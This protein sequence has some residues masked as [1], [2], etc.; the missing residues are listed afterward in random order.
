MKKFNLLYIIVIFSLLL[1]V[2]NL[3]ILN[4][5]R[6]MNGDARVVNYSGLV[7]GATQRLVKLELSYRPNDELMARLEEYLYGLAGY[8]NSY[9]IVYMDYDP[10]Q[11]SVGDLILIWDELK[12]SIYNYRE[13]LVTGDA[14]LEVSE[15]H[16]EKADEATHYAEY[17]SEGKIDGTV[18]LIRAGMI[19]ISVIVII[20]VVSLYL[21]R[22]SERRQMEILRENNQRLESAIHEANRA[23]RAKSI[24]LSNMSHDIRTPL[25]GIIG[26]TSI[27]LGNLTNTERMRD[28]LRKIENSSRL[29]QSLVNDVLDMSKIESGKFFLNSAEIFLPEFMRNLINVVGQQIKT[30]GQELKV[31][32]F[33]VI[34]ENI[35]GDQLRLNQLFLNI[36]SNSVKFTPAG[37][38]IG[39]IIT[40]LPCGR[41]GFACFEFICYDTG[42]GMS[43]EFLQIIFDSFSRE[44]DSRIDKIE[45]SGL[46]LS[47]TKRIVDIM[48]GGIQVE[49]EK[50]KGTK[51]TVRL[52]FPISGQD[53][54]L[55]KLD[56]IRVLVADGDEAVCADAENGLKSMGVSAVAKCNAA[57]VPELLSGGEKFDAVIIDWEMPGIS[58]HDLC[59]RIRRG[60][61]GKLPIIISSAREWNDIEQE[62]AD[63]GITGFIQKPLFRSSLLSKIREA[64][65]A[66]TDK[67]DISTLRAGLRLDG[68]HILMAE[69]NDLNTEIAVEILTAAGII[70]DCA[71]N[72]KEAVDIFNG[73]EIF[74]YD[75]ILMDMQMPVMTGCEASAAIRA[76]PRADASSIPI[77]AMTANAFEED[78]RE[79][80]AAG[81]NAHVSKPVNFE[82]L[83]T[84]ISKFISVASLKVPSPAKSETAAE[85]DSLLEAVIPCGVNVT[86]GLARFAGNRKAYEK[87]L[88]KYPDDK[89]FGALSRAILSEDFNAALKAAHTLK[90][91]A[92]NLSMD[93]FAETLFQL[94]NSLKKANNSQ[95]LD[96]YQQARELNEALTEVIRRFVN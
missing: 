67:P 50:N 70:L 34:H 3:L 53:A 57:D 32:A 75:A 76:L 78:I 85:P 56:G 5:V 7:R 14:L 77:I 92:L 91:I 44:K 6:E 33:S 52:E 17:G 47:I 66:K 46:G 13:G 37:G 31:S 20:V 65:S 49:S 71:I 94:E 51:F 59:E 29:L 24:F 79:A 41:E 43:E 42:I 84:V 93:T 23:N 40:E 55:E 15:R 88:L 86:G 11:E 48:E 22:R 64:L 45:G 63:A 28:C 12:A 69:D 4:A 96:L 30:K 18:F 21:L 60:A 62:A 72:G 61:D 74:G 27:A 9:D 35:L 39:L 68:A 8:E 54:G 95:C 25:N 82:T 90:G 38:V 89:N 87:I 58:G 36:L 81:M 80:L 16:F 2:Q 83:K 10:F 1:L 26:M 73:S 19:A